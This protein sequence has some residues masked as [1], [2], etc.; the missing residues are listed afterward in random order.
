MPNRDPIKSIIY[1]GNVSAMRRS[2]IDRYLRALGNLS[3]VYIF[4]AKRMGE[5]IA[6]YC[7]ETDIEVKGF[8]DNDESMQNTYVHG[9]PVL[10]PHQ[11]TERDTTVIVASQYLFDISCQLTNDDFLNVLP[12]PVLSIYDSAVFPPEPTYEGLLEDLACSTGKYSEVYKLLYDK[13]SKDILLDI[14]R[15]RTS[16][17]P[18]HLHSAGTPPE[19]QYFDNFISLSDIEVFVDGG[20]FNGD[21]VNR[22]LMKT[23]GIY[24]RIHFFEP[25]LALLSQARQ[26]L[27]GYDNIEFYGEGLFSKDDTL[28]FSATGNLDGRIIDNG[29][30]SIKVRALDN[31]VD[32]PVTFIKLDVEGAELAAIEGARRHIENDRPVLAVCV[33]HN[34]SDL[35]RLPLFIQSIS[36]EYNYSLRHY[37]QAFFETVIYCI[38]KEQRAI[39]SDH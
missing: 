15:F 26:N 38:P 24:K 25:D 6:K 37:S 5:K 16:F 11:A 34:P 10:K 17:D 27:V 2:V 31:A 32:E 3:S 28:G 35:W 23:N 4:G 36:K 39:V 29:E 1:Q 19:L 7:Q 30:Q 8:L 12:Y 21:T 20:G 22:F 9:I 18:R 33:Y 13:R 14:L